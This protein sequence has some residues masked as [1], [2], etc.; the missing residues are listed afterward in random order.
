MMQY[1][2]LALSIVLGAVG[3]ILFKQGVKGIAETQLSMQFV[4]SCMTNPWILLGGASYGAS[5]I[6][7]LYILRFFE[8]SF[9]R[10]LTGFGY[11]LTYVIAIVFLGEP[12]TPFRVIAVVLITAGVILLVMDVSL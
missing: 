11:I 6:L 2:F 4:F 1:T 5:F 7:W 12:I 8:I 3:Q 10:P 9:A